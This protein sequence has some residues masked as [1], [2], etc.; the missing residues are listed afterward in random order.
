MA[1]NRDGT[2]LIENARLMFRN[3][4]GREQTFNSAGDRNFCIM[5]EDELAE[6][7]RA[8]GW[9]IKELKPRDEGDLPQPYVQVKVNYG[10]GR[11]PRV[12]LVTSRG[13]NDLGAD[14]IALMDIADIQKVDVIIR[15]YDWEIKRGTEVTTGR[16]AYLKTLFATLNEDELEMKYADMIEDDRAVDASEFR[17]EEP[18]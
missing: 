13:R 7:M 10:K 11:P 8:D 15:P 6:Q 4:A 9:N 1:P 17:I 3:F 16:K 12:C 5:L 14:E 18:A 2:I